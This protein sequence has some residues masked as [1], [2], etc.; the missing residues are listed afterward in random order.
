MS[1][2]YISRDNEK[3][4]SYACFSHWLGNWTNS[5]Y[6]HT[7]NKISVK[8]SFR[9]KL[10]VREVQEYISA[11][12]SLWPEG[13]WSYE[14]DE[15]EKTLIVHTET[16]HWHSFSHMYGLWGACRYVHD[17][18]ATVQACLFFLRKYPKK[19]NF[20]QALWLGYIHSHHEWRNHEYMNLSFIADGRYNLT[21]LKDAKLHIDRFLSKTALPG[22]GMSQKIWPP[23]PVKEFS[24]I[25][26]IMLGTT[27]NLN[28][29]TT[30]APFL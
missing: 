1:N 2:Q 9:D 27:Y 21:W 22:E 6:C 16:K 19:L 17:T 7:W 23:R 12:Y 13:I 20:F 25:S 26:P 5:A 8:W 30:L 18:P 4:V 28:T 11:F 24:K 10:S 14:I 29:F 3:F 15:N